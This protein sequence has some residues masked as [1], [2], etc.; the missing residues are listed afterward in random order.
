MRFMIQVRATRDTEASVLPSATRFAAMAAY[1]DNLAKAGVLLDAAGLQPSA[2]GWRVHYR[3]GGG[4]TVVDGPFAETQALIA[5]YTLIQVRDREEAMEW[6][7]R[8]PPPMGE[9]VA[10]TIEVRQL[11]ESEDFPPDAAM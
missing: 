2:K 7:R 6:V 3:A 8:F 9:N 1:H 11:F 10:A 5:G 4:T